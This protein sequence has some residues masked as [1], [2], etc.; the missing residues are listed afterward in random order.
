M[1]ITSPGVYPANQDLVAILDNDSLEPIFSASI[2]MRVS[3]NPSKMITQYQVEDGTIR[4]D[5][6]VDNPLEMNIDLLLS[7]LKRAEYLGLEQS[8]NE[9]R[10]VIV[11][12]T[13]SSYRNMIIEAMPHD[14]TV[15]F[16][17]NVLLN[18]RLI[19]W[20]EITP[21]YGDLPPKK[22]VNKNKSSTVK[23][24]TKNTT[25]VTPSPENNTTAQD[26]AKVLGFKK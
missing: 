20:R 21:S 19:E 10:L 18:I 2:P 17:E 1:A 12:T 3:V 24:G 6:V 23:S 4:N 8:F 13:I 26:I 16:G 22:V 7:D 9:L 25:V 14:E 5:H 15:D 11:Q